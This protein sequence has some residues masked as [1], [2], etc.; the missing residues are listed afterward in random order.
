ME[1]DNKVENEYLLDSHEKC[2]VLFP[3]DWHKMFDFS[4]DAVLLVLASELFNVEDYIYEK[5]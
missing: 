4:E 2:L 5:Y 1:N 3:E